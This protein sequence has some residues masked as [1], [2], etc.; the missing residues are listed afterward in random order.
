MIY[1]FEMKFVNKQSQYNSNLWQ[2]IPP[3][4]AFKDVDDWMHRFNPSF[5]A[6]EPSSEDIFVSLGAPEN[7]I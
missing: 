2:Q 3:L 4:I 7:G 6:D 5:Y 1:T